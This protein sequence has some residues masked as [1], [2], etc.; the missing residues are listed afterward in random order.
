MKTSYFNY[1]KDKEYLH[2]DVV[3]I[4]AY[5]PRFLKK[6]LTACKELA[7]SR[8]N[9]KLLKEDYDKNIDKYNNDYMKQL[10]AL[11]DDFFE[12]FKGK[13]L[14]CYEKEPLECH[15]RMMA[16]FYEKKTGIKVE[17]LGMNFGEHL[18]SFIKKNKITDFKEEDKKYLKEVYNINI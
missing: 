1:I 2:K 14:C 18:K 17:E 12:Q 7:P 4:S 16:E 3:V 6:G 9:L 5:Y 10:E 13:I 11:S 8:E 15:R